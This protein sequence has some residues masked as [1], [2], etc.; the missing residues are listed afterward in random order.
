MCLPVLLPGIIT[1]DDEDENPQTKCFAMRPDLEDT[2]PIF[3]DDVQ[4]AI[5]DAAKM[6]VPAS[7]PGDFQASQLVHDEQPDLNDNLVTE[8][9]AERSVTAVGPASMPVQDT[10]SCIIAVDFD[11]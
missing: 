11:I 6:D 1:L 7:Q 2:Q 8:A 9:S 4:M 3:E 10:C 5:A